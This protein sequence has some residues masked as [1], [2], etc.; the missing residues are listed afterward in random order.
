VIAQP[1]TIA[2]K[3]SPRIPNRLLSDTD[4]DHDGHREYVIYR[5]DA[6]NYELEVLLDKIEIAGKPICAFGCRDG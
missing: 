1:P 4:I 2:R 5:P 3:A 6:N